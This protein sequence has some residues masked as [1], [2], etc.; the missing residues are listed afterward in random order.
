MRN[1]AV[2]LSIVVALVI[3]QVTIYASLLK[4]P[5]STWGASPE[6]AIASMPGDNLSTEYQST[7]AIT[8]NASQSVTWSWLNQLG[9]DRGGFFSYYFI[10]QFLGYETRPQTIVKPEFP[11][12][13]PGD[14]IRGSII[15]SKSIIVYEFPVVATQTEKYIVARN[16][17]TFLLHPINENQTRLIIRTHRP[18]SDSLMKAA[19]DYYIAEGLHFVMERATLRG[20]KARVEAGEGPVFDD[21]QDRLWFF[22]IVASAFTIAIL[23]FL[24]RRIGRVIIPTVLSTIWT[25]TLL[26]FDPVPLYSLMLL[27]LVSGLIGNNIFILKMRL[28]KQN[29]V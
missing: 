28:T 7:R 2:S 24:M 6:E 20:F 21:V 18:E 29:G 22:G 8:I 5:T 15:P 12:L 3:L 17:G 10:E 14:V 19:F 4:H 1:L 16:W 11:E 25:I 13:M 23:I 26:V 9:A 27:V